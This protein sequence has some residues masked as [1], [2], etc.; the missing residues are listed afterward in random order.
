MPLTQD[1]IQQITQ[2]L[3]V[4]AEPNLSDMAFVFGA[5]FIQP[6]YIAAELFKM[7]LVKYIALTGG[8]NRLTEINEANTFYEVLIGMGISEAQIILENE[9]TNTLENVIFAIPQIAARMNIQD[10]KSLIVITK[11]Y[12]SRRAIMTLKRHFP[13][14]IYYFT[15]TYEPEGIGRTDWYLNEE[16]TRVVKKEWDCIPQYLSFGHLAEIEIRPNTAI[17]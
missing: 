9:S 7:G 3:D 4:N 13:D 17:I 5:R 14:R 8:K 15:K 6:A 10:V 11:W 2:Y 12:H 1:E 16:A